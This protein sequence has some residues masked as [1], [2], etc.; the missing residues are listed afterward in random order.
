MRWISG[1][2]DDFFVVQGFVDLAVILPDQVWL[3]DFK[4]D[5]VSGAE[6]EAK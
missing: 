3:L 5:A 2:A 1:L 6:V 4:T